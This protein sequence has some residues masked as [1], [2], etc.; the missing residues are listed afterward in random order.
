[1]NNPWLDALIYSS[2]DYHVAPSCKF[3]WFTW[4]AEQSKTITAVP[5]HFFLPWLPWQVCTWPC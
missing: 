3:C 1:M 2:L 4:H 5:W